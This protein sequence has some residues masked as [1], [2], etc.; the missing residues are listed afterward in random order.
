MPKPATC[1]AEV[2]GRVIVCSLILAFII[3][4]KGKKFGKDGY[5]VGT[6][7]EKKKATKQNILVNLKS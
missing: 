6:Y 5:F 7:K 4:E 1:Y 2:W 3:L